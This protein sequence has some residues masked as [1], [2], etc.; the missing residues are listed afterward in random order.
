MTIVIFVYFICLVSELTVCN[1]NL[2]C[3][4]CKTVFKLDGAMSSNRNHTE[5]ECNAS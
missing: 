5:R 4:S 3:F 1:T 2:R